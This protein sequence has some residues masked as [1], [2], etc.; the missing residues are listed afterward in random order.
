MRKVHARPSK[1]KDQAIRAV[2]FSTK[3]ERSRVS[4][5]TSDKKEPNTG[6]GIR[7]LPPGA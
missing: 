2:D 6:P 4:H 7:G 5:R 1:E 3:G